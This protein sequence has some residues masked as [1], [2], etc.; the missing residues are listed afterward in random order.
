MQ[1]FMKKFIRAIGNIFVVAAILFLLI[2]SFVVVSDGSLTRDLFGFII[3][4]PPLWTGWI[5]YL[6]YIIALF[7]GWFSIHGLI[8]VVIIALL[9]GVGMKLISF[10]QSK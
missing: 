5:P 10:G 6:G 4:Y 8:G 3:P 1:K 9:M 7:Y 2:H